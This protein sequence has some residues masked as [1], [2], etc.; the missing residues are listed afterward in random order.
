MAK[1]NQTQNAS[2]ETVSV[3]PE[4]VAPAQGTTT[5]VKKSGTA[6]SLLALL[7]ALG[8][9][10]AGFYLGQQQLEGIQ[11]QLSSLSVTT[12]QTSAP[13]FDAK[14]LVPLEEANKAMQQQLSRVESQIQAKHRNW[15]HYRLRSIN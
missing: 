4:A 3:A 12:P 13:A 14:V 10:G 8:V 15:L 9:G 1:E 11:Q 2:E 6:L 7:V 5:I